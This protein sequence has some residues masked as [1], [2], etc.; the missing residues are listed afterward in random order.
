AELDGL[1]RFAPLVARGDVEDV[2]FVGSEPTMLRLCT[3][4]FIDGPPIADSD[5]DLL[6]LLRAIGARSGDGQTSRELSSASPT[7]NVRLKGVTEL[8]ARLQAAT[9]VLPRPA[10]VIRV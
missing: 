6:R 10:G 3:G 5:E 1:G 4:Q 8:G 2:H 7:L 9:D